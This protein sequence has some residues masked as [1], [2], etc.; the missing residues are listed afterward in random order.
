MRAGR[1]VRRRW[2]AEPI[3][4]RH[5]RHGRQ[6][7]RH[8]FIPLSHPRAGGALEGARGPA[9]GRSFSLADERFQAIHCPPPPKGAGGAEASEGTSLLDEPTEQA[10]VECQRLGDGGGLRHWNFLKQTDSAPF[11]LLHLINF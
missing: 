11:P 4:C 6:R 5:R 8:R 3:S 2:P 10:G 1:Q 7:Y 9:S